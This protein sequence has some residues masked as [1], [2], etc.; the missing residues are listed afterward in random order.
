M[1]YLILLF[2]KEVWWVVVHTKYR[3]YLLTHL[4]DKLSWVELT[5]SGEM[6]GSLTININLLR[7]RESETLKIMWN[8]L[9]LVVSRNSAIIDKASCIHAQLNSPPWCMSMSWYL[10]KAL[11]PLKFLYICMYICDQNKIKM[12][13][14]DHTHALQHQHFNIHPYPWTTRRNWESLQALGAEIE[15][16]GTENYRWRHTLWSIW[17]CRYYVAT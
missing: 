14:V 11:M 4:W 1:K 3:D 17:H 15:E 13:T 10:L 16:P 6:S 8:L 12:M 7:L 5:E 2:R 9:V